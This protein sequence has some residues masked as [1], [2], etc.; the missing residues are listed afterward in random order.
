[1][2]QQGITRIEAQAMQRVRTAPAAAATGWIENAFGNC[3]SLDNGT[4]GNPG[5]APSSYIFYSI[6]LTAQVTGCFQVG[7]HYPW[8]TGTTGDSVTLAVKSV[9]WTAAAWAPIKTTGKITLA[10]ASSSSN[11]TGPAVG[12]AINGGSAPQGYNCTTPGTSITA[13][14][15]GAGSATAT[16]TSEAHGS[17][18]GLLTANGMITES[19]C[20]VDNGQGPAGYAIGSPVLIEFLVS[21]TNTISMTGS[22]AFWACEMPPLFT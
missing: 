15:T 6:L 2:R 17:L 21:A 7:W 18:T 11:G 12:P 14:I 9:G 16:L 3:V 4:V 20:I 13:T 10:N 5:A 1:M 8:N 19:G 22:A